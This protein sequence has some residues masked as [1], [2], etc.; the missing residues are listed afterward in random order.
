[1]NAT[2]RQRR[3]V[4]TAL[5]LP[6]GTLLAVLLLLP[7]I[8]VLSFSLTDYQFGMPGFDWVGLANYAKLFTDPDIRRSLFNTLLYVVMVAPLSIFAALALAILI[9]GEGRLGSVFQTIY[10]LPITATL[11]AMATAWEVAL[12]PTF[13]MVNAALSA[14]GFAKVRFLSDPDTAL[15]TLAVIGVW[16]ILGYNTLLFLAGLATIDRDLY[17]AAAI[18]GADGGWGRF[19][20]VTWPQLAPVTLFVTVITLIRCFS[21]FETVAVLTNGG[22]SGATDMILFTLYQQAFR[23]FDIGVASA[24]AVAFLLFVALLSIVQVSLFER[25]GAA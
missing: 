12:H 5:A 1:M 19:T 25:G 9:E 8:G 10:F 3:R 11:V 4:G 24:L 17:E 14:F 6:A 16:K 7:S 2:E 22:P 18:D 15:A 13:G 21:E 20:L 23:Y